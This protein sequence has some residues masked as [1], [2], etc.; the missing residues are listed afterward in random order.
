MKII[1]EKDYKISGGIANALKRGANLKWKKTCSVCGFSVPEYSGRYPKR[2]PL[3]QTD[4]NTANEEYSVYQNG[5]SIGHVIKNIRESS[6]KD[7]LEAA[8][9]YIIK[10]V[11]ITGKDKKDPDELEAMRKIM[12]IKKIKDLWTTL[13]KDYLFDKPQ[14]TQLKMDLVDVMTD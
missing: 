6:D 4:F 2:C 10:N 14:M 8:K 9:R 5:V 12:K 13:E 1:N 11:E 7:K 3:C